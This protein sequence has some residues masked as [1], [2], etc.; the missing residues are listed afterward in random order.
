MDKS[1][2][3]IGKTVLFVNIFNNLGI[4]PEFPSNNDLNKVP[5][6][7]GGIIHGIKYNGRMIDT[8]F[9]LFVI[10]CAAINPSPTERTTAKKVY[11]IVFERFNLKRCS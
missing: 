6:A 2:S 4:G 11:I 5:L 1:I 3:P 10:K 8:N 9:E 7:T